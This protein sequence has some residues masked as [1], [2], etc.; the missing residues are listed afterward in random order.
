MSR[1]CN[2]CG[3]ITKDVETYCHACVA[4]RCSLCYE[5]GHIIRIPFLNKVQHEQLHYS[6]S[7]K[8]AES[9]DSYES[10][11][12]VFFVHCNSELDGCGNICPST[13]THCD[14]GKRLL[15]KQYDFKS[16]HFGQPI[17]FLRK[18]LSGIWENGVIVKMADEEENTVTV[19]YTGP[20]TSQWHAARFDECHTR[21][22]VK[23][24]EEFDLFSK[25]ARKGR[26]AA[27]RSKL[28]R[29][30]EPYVRE[31]ESKKSSGSSRSKKTNQSSRC[32]T[33]STS[34]DLSINPLS[35]SIYWDHNEDDSDSEIL[36]DSEEK[37]VVASHTS[38]ENKKRKRY[39]KSSIVDNQ[40][41]ATDTFIKSELV[42]SDIEDR[43]CSEIPLELLSKYILARHQLKPAYSAVNGR[44]FPNVD[45]NAQRGLFF[46]LYYWLYPTME[47]RQNESFRRPD[48]S[49]N[50]LQELLIQCPTT[51]NELKVMR[52]FEKLKD[53]IPPIDDSLKRSMEDA[54]NVAPEAKSLYF[55]PDDGETMGHQVIKVIKFFFDSRQLQPSY[56][57][58]SQLS[59]AIMQEVIQAKNL[60]TFL[61]ASLAQALQSSLT[62][63]KV[64]IPMTYD[65]FLAVMML[66][67]SLI[68]GRKALENSKGVKGLVFQKGEQSGSGAMYGGKFLATCCRQHIRYLLSRIVLFYAVIFQYLD[69]FDALATYRHL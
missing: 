61:E 13:E 48:I 42:M 66:A 50:E 53:V 18:G 47:L 67:Y 59:P 63:M 58:I 39:S 29:K 24:V 27:T 41:D 12:T 60:G 9:C 20:S 54:K 52:C 8:L 7:L 2:I 5:L 37:C 45:A 62:Q 30:Y 38:P 31:T 65:Q 32:R 26:T 11:N 19:R 43:K 35:D 34:T 3:Y 44:P 57:R 28:E 25:E 17:Y 51:M 22:E 6:K 15:S 16:L 49:V 69:K 10:R 36:D 1:S 4:H 14:C 56:T 55:I 46:T 33:K 23:S 64:T 40:L 21:N 68:G